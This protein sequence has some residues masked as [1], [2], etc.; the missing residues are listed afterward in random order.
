MYEN[1][2][3]TVILQSLLEGVSTHFIFTND[4]R[5]SVRV[6]DIFLCYL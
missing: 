3:F 5:N 4:V 2:V 6:V 1:I